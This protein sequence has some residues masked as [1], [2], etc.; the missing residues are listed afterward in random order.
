MDESSSRTAWVSHVKQTGLV[1]FQSE[2]P[3]QLPVQQLAFHVDT[4]WICHMAAAGE[5]E[6]LSYAWLSAEARQ[7]VFLREP[8]TSSRPV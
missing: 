2:S 6:A 8:D 3:I 7:S 1:M 4:P 5:I